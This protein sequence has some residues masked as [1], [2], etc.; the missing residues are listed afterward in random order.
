[1]RLGGGGDELVDCYYTRVFCLFSF[2]FNSTTDRE[3][4]MWFGG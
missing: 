3:L 1:M 2:G 4:A